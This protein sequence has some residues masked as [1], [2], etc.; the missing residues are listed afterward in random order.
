MLETG[1]IQAF[2]SARAPKA[3]MEGSP[4]VA[5]LFPDYE[6]VERDYHRRTGVFPIMHT[7]VARKALLAEYPRLARAIYD[8]FTA[9]KDAALDGYRKAKVEMNILT[10]VPWLTPLLSRN[11]SQF[12]RDWWPYGVAANREVIETFTRYFH[13]QGLSSRRFRCEDIFAEELLNT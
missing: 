7:V 13:E 4:K 1:E 6:A 2:F 3:F 8:A 5:R 9:A 10:P 11:E 12:Q